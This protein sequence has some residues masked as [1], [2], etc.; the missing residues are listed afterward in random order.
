MH[1]M[2]IHNKTANHVFAIL[3]AFAMLSMQWAGLHHKIAHADRL[4]AQSYTVASVSAD[5]VDQDKELFHSCLLFDA[6]TLSAALQN[7]LI[8]LSI[9]AV[10]QAIRE[11]P[12]LSWQAPFNSYF[13]SRAPPFALI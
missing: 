10:S 13:L 7:A 3:F 5:D 6:V 2:R 1:L 12:L 4:Q 8:D 11:T 9:S